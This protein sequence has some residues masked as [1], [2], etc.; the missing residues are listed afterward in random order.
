MCLFGFVFDAE[1]KD[2]ATLNPGSGDLV[3]AVRQMSSLLLVL[4]GGGAGSL[5]SVL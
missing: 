3:P 5:M 1:E 2:E 4:L